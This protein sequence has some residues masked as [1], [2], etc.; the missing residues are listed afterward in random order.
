[1]WRGVGVQFEEDIHVQSVKQLNGPFE[2]LEGLLLLT[3]KY[4]D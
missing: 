3:W 1:M 2:D 4:G